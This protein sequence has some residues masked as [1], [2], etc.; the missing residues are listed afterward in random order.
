VSD[1]SLYVDSAFAVCH[2]IVAVHE[3]QFGHLVAPGTWYSGAERRS[4]AVEAR[5]AAYAAG[6]LEPAPDG[7]E[8]PDVELPAFV[9]RLVQTI[10][11]SVQELTQDFYERALADGLTEPEY[12]EVVG[13]VSGV[14]DLDVFARGIGVPPR[15]LP[16]PENGDASR[17][18]PP[19]AVLEHAWVRTVPNGAA[20]GEI[21]KS[22]YHGQ[23]MPYIVR[24]LS[25]VPEELRAHV[26]L[27]VAHYTRLD[28]LFDYSYQHHDGL[29]RPQ[30]EL[31]A[32][33]V[34]ALNDCFY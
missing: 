10:A 5:R 15:P 18:L 33:R 2:E 23:P 29:T 11:T 3:R 21:G 25:L 20:G 13:V 6:L 16:R 32:G 14:V 8:K 34:S 12:V 24:A 26:E 22:L 1:V 19:T 31:V 7:A 28:K 30:A 9:R 27:E 17:E 4:I